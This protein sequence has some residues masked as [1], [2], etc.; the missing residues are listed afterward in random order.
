MAEYI[1]MTKTFGNRL[2]VTDKALDRL[3]D[4]LRELTR[5]TRGH[6]IGSVIADI[7]K[8]LLGWKAYFGIA[9]VQ[10]A[11]ARKVAVGHQVQQAALATRRDRR[12]ASQ[13]CR[14]RPV[15]IHHTQRAWALRHQK[16]AFRQK[17]HGP[18]IHQT[19]GH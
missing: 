9:E 7:R 2:K 15:G 17:G 11:V 14:N 8:A 5:R 19:G 4:K 6:N 1:A 18:G 3:K 16:A 13:R 12:N 10:P